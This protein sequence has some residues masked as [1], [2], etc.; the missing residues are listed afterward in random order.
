MIIIMSP[1][2]YYEG[3]ESER[4]GRES[5]SILQPDNLFLDNINDYLYNRFLNIGNE[6]NFPFFICLY[7]YYIML[8]GRYPNFLW[9]F[10]QYLPILKET[11]QFQGNIIIKTKQKDYMYFRSS[12]RARFI[13][14]KKNCPEVVFKEENCLHWSP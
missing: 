6:Y 10:K 7:I 9:L 8:K 3:V 13:L 1:S 5:R 11:M 4:P 2:N 12:T 14:E